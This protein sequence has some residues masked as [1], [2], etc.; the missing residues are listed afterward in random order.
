MT[1]N[2]LL[3]DPALSPVDI[4]IRAHVRAFASILFPA[5]VLGFA[6][7]MTAFVLA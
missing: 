3:P 2:Q 5:T 1:R 6:I 7:C 4:Q